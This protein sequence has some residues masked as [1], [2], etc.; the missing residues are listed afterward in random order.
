MKLYISSGP[1]HPCPASINLL[2]L[3]PMDSSPRPSGCS[4]ALALQAY[5]KQDDVFYSQLTVRE[6]LL[7][8]ARLR[9]PRD[10]PL[11]DKVVMVDELISKLGLSKVWMSGVW[12]AALC[13]FLSKH[14]C[15]YRRE[16]EVGEGRFCRL[17]STSVCWSFPC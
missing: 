13:S 17:P 6:T 3:V 5:V 8:A 14:Q 2:R 10:V 15:S 12:S 4:S 1:T 11:E 16:A 9:L 7:M